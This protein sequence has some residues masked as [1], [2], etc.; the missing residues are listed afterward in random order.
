[1]QPPPDPGLQRDGDSVEDQAMSKNL[2]HT[3]MSTNSFGVFRKY[4]TIPSHNLHDPDTFTD[5]PI[6]TTAPQSET[7]GSSLMAAA[8]SPTGSEHDPPTESKNRSEDLLLAWMT[9]GSG[10]TPTGMNN[11]VH[12]TLRHPDFNLSE[13]D[14]FNAVTATR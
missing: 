2:T 12:N 5:I 3:I 8:V 9:L 4:I 7:I 1:M 14:N 10:N 11:L 13:L 6:A